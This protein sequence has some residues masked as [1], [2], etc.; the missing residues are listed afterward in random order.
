MALEISIGSREIAETYYR[1]QE[2]YDEYERIRDLLAQGETPSAIARALGSQ[3]KR[4]RI[5]KYKDGA[6]PR[7]FRA[8]SDLEKRGLL[9][10][11]LE[12]NKFL[13]VNLLTSISFWRGSRVQA[14]KEGN[15][16]IS[17]NRINP[18]TEVQADI[19][20]QLLEALD[21]RFKILQ[22]GHL[23]FDQATG[24]LIEALGYSTG[25]KMENELILPGYI[26]V[27]LELFSQNNSP[28]ML[29][30][31]RDFIDTMIVF[32]GKFFRWG[33]SVNL[34]TYRKKNV[35]KRHADR[36]VE[37][38]ELAAPA[39]K[40]R[41][42]KPFRHSDTDTVYY[43]LH[44]DPRIVEQEIIEAYQGRVQKVLRKDNDLY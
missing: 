31:L 22:D 38:M 26:E 8:I 27:I 4:R 41:M 3:G 35:A 16:T 39:Y 14:R 36:V 1:G 2:F 10:M 21:C 29:Q 7:C 23:D 34:N 6:R 32:R 44:L 12:H 17:T 42:S 13:A 33:R 24:R 20:K 9:P 15:N 43:R 18:V 5:Q 30:I 28:E 25:S 11:S 40:P 19:A 37:M